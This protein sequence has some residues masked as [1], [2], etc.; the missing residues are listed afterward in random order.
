MYVHGTPHIN[1]YIEV[2]KL[3]IPSY[4]CKITKSYLLAHRCFL[5][6]DALC[7]KARNGKYIRVPVLCNGS[8]IQ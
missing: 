1:Y 6:F 5:F 8:A 4:S 2:E 7:H 3:N